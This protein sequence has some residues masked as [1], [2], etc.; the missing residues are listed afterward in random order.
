MNFNDPE[1]LKQFFAH[2]IELCNTEVK[3]ALAAVEQ[4]NLDD[5]RN[6]RAQY[7]ENPENIWHA[8]SSP[9]LI[10]MVKLLQDDDELKFPF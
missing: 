8:V 4:L 1:I 6:L 2:T 9:N 3:S 5:L 10:S 7:M